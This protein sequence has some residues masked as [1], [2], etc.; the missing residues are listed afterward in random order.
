MT[1]RRFVGHARADA[2]RTVECRAAWDTA[3]CHPVGMRHA[4]AVVALAVVLLA[5][6]TGTARDAA[7]SSTAPSTTPAPTT[8]DTPMSERSPTLAR[9]VEQAVADLARRLDVP[10]GAITVVSAHE[11][12]W[13]DT[14]LG[15]P[16]PGMRYAQVVT[17][18]TKV[19]L[20]HD[21]ATYPY[22]SGGSRTDPFLCEQEPRR[23]PPPTPITPPPTDDA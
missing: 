7:P 3:L 12:S 17:D 4:P 1:R 11:V 19:V 14:S 9:I 5:A 23:S 6:C 21:G 16:Q 8:S 10:P 20:E 18:G 15:C 2:G 13:G 22:H